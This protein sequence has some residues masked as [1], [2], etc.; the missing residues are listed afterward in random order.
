VLLDLD[1]P[2]LGGLD[3]C[4]RL[5][6]CDRWQTLPILFL[7]ACRESAT[8]YQLYQA[9][10]DDYLPKPILEPELINRLFQRLERGTA[11]ANSGRHRPPHRLGQPPK[12]PH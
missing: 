4:R 9:G 11:A 6:Q 1:M 3:I 5:R 2:H 10:A 8:V 12:G 7:T